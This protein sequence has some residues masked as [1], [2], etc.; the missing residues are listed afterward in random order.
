MNAKDIAA[1]LGAGR[2]ACKAERSTDR[3]CAAANLVPAI[4]GLPQ[5]KINAMVN[6]PLDVL[7]KNFN[8]AG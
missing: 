7:T 8:G 5:D 4:A 2:A 6:S 3:A 1:L